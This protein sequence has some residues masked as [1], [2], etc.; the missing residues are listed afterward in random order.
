VSPTPRAA[1]LL[2]IA[3]LASLAL[4]LGVALLAGVAA[5]CAT[6]VDA[7]LSRRV[8]ELVRTAPAVLYRGVRSSL[9][10]APEDGFSPGALRLRQP[11]PPDLRLEPSEADGRL[12]GE[13]T[14]LR[15]GRHELPRAAVRVTGPLGLGCTYRRALADEEV[16][17]YPNLPAAWRVVLAVRQG[18]FRQ[19]GRQ[20][21]GP[22]GLGTD[23]ESI[24]DYLPDDD[25]RQINWPA[26][27]RLGRPMSNQYRVE[28]DRDVICVL[29]T[30]RLMA[31][32]L[33]DR[34]RLDAAVDAA[35][36]VA[37]VADE[38]G[39]RCGTVAFDRELRRTV[40]PRRRGAGAVV[41]ALFDL[42]PSR[43]ESDYE[44]AFHAVGDAKRALV[45]VFTDLLE[46]SAARPLLNALPVL[47]RR[48]AVAVASA[49]DTD[50]DALLARAPERPRDV[51]ATAAALDVLAARA[52][53]AALLRR[54][55]VDVVEA[56][57][58]AL[59][60]AC[61]RVYLRAKAR[62]RL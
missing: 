52:R 40:G 28:Q 48:H 14:P 50:L 24:R 15:R 6:A 23:F 33:G 3:A 43:V 46:E 37:A 16:L 45:I 36:T 41:R 20:T 26:T 38:V 5:V 18:R 27:S 7:Y 53:V 62:A 19:A 44:L 51:Y 56:A 49:A 60:A 30:G 12:E 57:P 1:A 11:V 4:P 10:L 25:V 54:A 59:G 22:L 55:G 31:A 35:V 13:L 29:D 2:G 21:R 34:T 32:P 61:V 8:P 47:R 9:A 58:D 39:D 42:E 17:V